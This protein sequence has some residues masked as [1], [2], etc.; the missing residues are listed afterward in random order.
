M[1]NVLIVVVIILAYAPAVFSQEINWLTWDEVSEKMHEEP[2]KVLVDVYT[3][4][5]GYCKK[6]DKTT[7]VD[8]SLV[9]Y[10]N[11]NYYAIKFDAESKKVI[12]MHGKEY[13]FINQGKNG[14]HELASVILRG[15]LKYPSLVFMDS[16]L[17]VIQPIPGYRDAK[18]LRMI[19]DYYEGD[20]HKK[21]PWKTYTQNYKVK[22][23]GIQPTKQIPVYNVGSGG[24]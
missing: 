23:S 12:N 8:S 14:Y 1:K 2:R 24:N 13:K 9:N 4:W 17:E 5:C 6:M 22:K 18:T 19:L 7:F 16:N 15:R 11:K 21:M 10:I 3:E 20:N